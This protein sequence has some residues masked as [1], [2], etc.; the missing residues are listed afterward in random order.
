MIDH[1]TQHFNSM[2]DQWG[3]QAYAQCSELISDGF[4]VSDKGVVHS[5]NLLDGRG[6]WR[7]SQIMYLAPKVCTPLLKAVPWPWGGEFLHLIFVSEFAVKDVEVS[8]QISILLF[9]G[10]N[11]RFRN[12]CTDTH[13]RRYR[14]CW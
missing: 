10:H 11:L 8:R 3:F 2:Y 12:T 7:L 4:E 6:G 14:E 1:M 9:D 13:R 5:R